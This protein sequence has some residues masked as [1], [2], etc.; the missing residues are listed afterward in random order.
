MDK[1][2]DVP[3]LL[4]NM[5]PQQ[6]EGILSV[7]GPVLLLAGAG[8]GKTCVIT[9]RIA[10]LIQERGVLPDSIIDESDDRP[11]AVNGAGGVALRVVM[12]TA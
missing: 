2:G 7:D 6:R 1:I 3:D 4:A 11:P 5:N 12:K 8:S 10:Y 9:H